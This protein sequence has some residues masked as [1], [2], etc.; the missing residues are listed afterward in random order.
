MR[1]D[2]MTFVTVPPVLRACAVALIGALL[3]FLGP[4]GCEK[5][6]SA[7]PVKKN[8]IE[9]DGRVQFRLRQ[10]RFDIPKK[11]FKGVAETGAGIA[12]TAN[13]WALLLNFEG[14]DK[15]INHHDFY[16]VHHKGRRIQIRLLVRSRVMTVPQIVAKQEAREKYSVLG[17]RHRGGKYD[18]IHYGLE[19]Y[20]T[21]QLL[22]PTKLPGPSSVYLHRENDTPV[23]LFR[24]DEDQQV[25]YPGCSVRWDY[26]EDV[27]VRFDF[28]KKY[29]PQWRAIWA[30]VRRLL[31]GKLDCCST[32]ALS[33]R[34]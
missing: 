31:N 24:C 21:Y 9:K 23:L 14:F 20:R 26:N 5:S 16:E 10:T 29:L 3:L 28:S 22:G 1:K 11:Y 15:D 33:I 27:A 13:L 30:N 12:E 32:P 7:P 19:Y 18:E 17:G 25:S 6:N 8:V 34:H 4:V 2:S